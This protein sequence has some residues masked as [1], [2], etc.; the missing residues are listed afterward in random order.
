MS[1]QQSATVSGAAI[2]R[3]NDRP[4]DRPTERAGRDRKTMAAAAVDGV[5]EAMREGGGDGNLE[6]HAADRPYVA[7]S[8][9]SL[10]LGNRRNEGRKGGGKSWT[11]NT[12]S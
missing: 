8:L 3:L 11:K 5:H 6:G 2:D 10:S 12:C 7:R 4:T 9:S 1:E